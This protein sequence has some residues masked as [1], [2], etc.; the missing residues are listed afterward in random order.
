MKQQ[1]VMTE[2]DALT[3]A[4][5]YIV[6]QSDLQ[7]LLGDILYQYQLVGAR[8]SHKQYWAVLYNVTQVDAPENIMEGPVV[9]IIDPITKLAKFFD[10]IY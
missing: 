5:K 8:F 7:F 3:I 4:N 6:Q 1:S 2:K 9:V 10:E